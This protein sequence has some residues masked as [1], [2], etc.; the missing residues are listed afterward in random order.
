[1][2]KDKELIF[3]SVNKVEKWLEG[4]NYKG[5]DPADGLTSFLRPLTF[6]NLFLDRILQ[7]LIWRSPIN[8]RPLLG[9]KRLDSFIGRGYI[10]RAY[11]IMFKLS[12]D[13]SYMQKASAC[14]DWLMQNTAPGFDQYS[15]GKMFDFASRGGRQNKFEPITVWTSL[16]GQAFLD[17]YEIIGDRKYLI[18]ADSVCQWILK[19]PRT[20]TSSGFCINYTPFD[21]GDCTIHNQSM[22]AAAM[23]VRTAK[24]SINEEYLR[25]A[26]EAIKYTCTRQ[27]SDGSWY[28]GEEPTY[29]WIDNF[30]TGYNLDAL[31]S[32]IELTNDKTYEEKLKLGFSFYKSN[33]FENNGRPKYYHNRTYPI[34]S[35][36]AAQ[37]IDTLT[38]FSDY[39]DTA[40]ELAVR[41][42][43]WTIDNMQDRTGYFYFMRYPLVVLKP[44]MIHWAQATTY[45]ALAYL[46]SKM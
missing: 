29:H 40:L 46:L 42:A 22:L 7:Q 3:T 11:L 5:Y 4:H 33:F 45:K 13:D 16:I 38:Y 35:Q 23:L 34:D 32:Y 31:K 36:C 44:P 1:M 17:A 18:V 27:L 28:Y 39:D 19:V 25:V 30:H 12:G 21:K 15:W 43:K 9:V 2:K 24:F 8:L 41:V 37:A 20:Q 6:G 26:R 14:L 10:A